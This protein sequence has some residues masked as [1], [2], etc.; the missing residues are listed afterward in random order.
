[1]GG[2]NNL[3]PSTPDFAFYNVNGPNTTVEA[4][5]NFRVDFNATNKDLLAFSMYYVPT[6]NDSYNGQFV[7]MNLFHH[8]VINEAETFLWNH[9]FFSDSDK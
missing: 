6:S 5:Y 4:Q 8:K 2:A 9:T 3:D 1:L 7:P